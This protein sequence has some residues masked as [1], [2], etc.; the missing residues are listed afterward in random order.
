MKPLYPG[1]EQDLAGPGRLPKSRRRD[2]AHPFLK[3]LAIA[4][5]V[6]VGSTASTLFTWWLAAAAADRALSELRLPELPTTRPR[7]PSR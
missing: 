1:V 6:F 5:A 2:L 7:T 4:A 3:W